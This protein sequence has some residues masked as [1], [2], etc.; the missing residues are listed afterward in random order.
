MTLFLTCFYW[1]FRRKRR[2]LKYLIPMTILPKR[3]EDLWG[4][5]YN[6][7]QELV[8]LTLRFIGTLH[9]PEQSGH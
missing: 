9:I 5:Q 8:N 4:G 1:V 6:M 3:V 7:T 2:W